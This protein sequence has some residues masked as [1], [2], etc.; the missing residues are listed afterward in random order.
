MTKSIKITN[1]LRVFLVAILSV[2]FMIAAMIGGGS[3]PVAFAATNNEKQFDKT[4]VLDDL[5]G[6]VVGGNEF[7]LNDYPY[8]EN[9]KPQIIAFIE[10]GYSI[11]S[12]RDGNY[13]LYVYVY[14]PQGRAFDTST[15]RNRIEFAATDSAE[16]LSVHY[17]T[18]PLEFLNYSTAAGYEGLFYKFKIG[19]TTSEKNTILSA[20]G[21]NSRVYKISGI[22]LSVNG[23][24]TEYGGQGGKVQSY[25]YSGYALCYGSDLAT[26][27]TL[28]CKVDGFEKYLSLDVHSTYYRPKGTN[29]AAYERDTLHSVYFSVPNDIIVEYGEMTAVHATWL[30]ALTN[31]ALV[32]GN[33][34]VYNAILPYVGKTVDGGKFTYASDDNSPVRYALIAGAY[35]ESA[36]WNDASYGAAFVSYNDNANYT[37]SKKRITELQY[38][39]LADN[40]DADN[41]TLSAETLIEYFENYTKEHGG[42]LVADK[43]SADLFESYD[44]AFTDITIS[45]DDTFTLTDEQI[46]QSLWQKFVGG[47]Y[48]VTNTTEY[49]LSAIKKVEKSDF[50]STQAATCEGL[51]ID[52]SDY[53]EF[54]IFYDTS[55]KNNETV[56]LFRY[57]QSDYKCYEAIEYERGKGDFTI[58]GTN[59]GYD[60]IDTNAY[61]MQMW[62][63]LNFDII[64]LTFTK[65]GVDTVIPVVSSPMDI[66]ADANPPVITTDN[67]YDL[68][69][70]LF[71]VLM[72][73]I[74]L[75]LLAP[76][77]PY[78]IQFI[79]WLVLLPFKA[80]GALFKGIKKSVNSN[81]N[82]KK[83]GK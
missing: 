59:F 46:S 26:E 52:E 16:D 58:L 66:V 31:Y 48:N 40:A 47:G 63:Q 70:I 77:L 19:L 1:I 12:N 9:G 22:T 33:S 17:S 14:N 56:Y 64:D 79:V 76:I 20:V 15:E 28:T 62:V 49:T 82:T 50:K 30:N 57:Y 23:I 53:A 10:Y 73:I 8:D 18:Y 34:S 21:Q 60:Y 81:S 39:F 51:F 54:K 24:L 4:N 80:I 25:T 75:I 44:N 35:N 65:N 45:S 74:L 36:S 72:L 7:S 2:V 27:S 41:Y 69:K 71:A 42:N 67:D 61:F 78:V 11:Y 37:N 6:A 55:A 43:Y 83:R 32:T 68:L 3:Y 13:G 29:G 5:Q 38:C